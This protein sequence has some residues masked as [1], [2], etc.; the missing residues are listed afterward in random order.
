MFTEVQ[1]RQI[2]LIAN[3]WHGSAVLKRNKMREKGPCGIHAQRALAWP[4]V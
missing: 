1:R 3:E 4:K 2:F